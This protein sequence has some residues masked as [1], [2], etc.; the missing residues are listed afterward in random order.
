MDLQPFNVQ[1]FQAAASN[2]HEIYRV[3]TT[4]GGLYLPPEKYISL[5]FVRDIMVGLKKVK[6][7]TL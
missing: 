4:E 2:K 7:F 5:F 1:R 6:L 3:L